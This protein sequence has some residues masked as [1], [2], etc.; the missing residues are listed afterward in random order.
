MEGDGRDCLS[1]EIANAGLDRP[2]WQPQEGLSPPR[3]MLEPVFYPPPLISGIC[4]PTPPHL[5][6]GKRTM[7]ANLP[8]LFRVWMAKA[9]DTF[10]MDRPFTMAI[11]SRV[12]QQDKS[13]EMGQEGRGQTEPRGWSPVFSSFEDE[14]CL[15]SFP[16][17]RGQHPHCPTVGAPLPVAGRS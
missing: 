9:E 5:T 15:L 14:S 4:T 3:L 7:L 11:L 17:V 6:L 1:V 2:R 13:K 8:Q 12:L 10:S 16:N